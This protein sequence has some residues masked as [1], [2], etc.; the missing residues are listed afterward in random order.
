MSKKTLS[1]TNQELLLQLK[2][3]SNYNT[4]LQSKMSDYFTLDTDTY[5]KKEQKKLLKIIEDQEKF[6][7]ELTKQNSNLI[8][9]LKS[10]D[11]DQYRINEILNENVL[12]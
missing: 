2:R 4:F 11:Y 12:F 9:H 6:C 5:Y 7:L 8:N 10:I 1:Q 3:L